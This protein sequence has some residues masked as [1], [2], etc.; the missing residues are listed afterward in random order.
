VT[1]TPDFPSVTQSVAFAP[2]VAL[3]GK[4]PAA[5]TSAPAASPVFKNL[6]L[7]HCDIG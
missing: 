4:L 7:E 6:R 3:T 5:P 1:L 2:V